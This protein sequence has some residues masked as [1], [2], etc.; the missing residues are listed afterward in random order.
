MPKH[1]H[2]LNTVPPSSDAILFVGE[3]AARIAAGALETVQDFA[4]FGEAWVSVETGA[5][6]NG[7]YHVEHAV[8]VSE[9]D[10]DLPGGSSVR[11]DACVTERH[12]A[13]AISGSILLAM[14][15]FGLP[16]E[17][18]QLEERPHDEVRLAIQAAVDERWVA[19]EDDPGLCAHLLVERVNG[20]LNDV[21]TDREI[22]SLT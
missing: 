6:T 17:F 22:A 15:K 16:T 18:F 13:V 1:Y 2:H 11:V 19:P 4:D 21:E 14:N 10:D 5:S 8:T 12:L 20:I 3:I 9:L 7:I